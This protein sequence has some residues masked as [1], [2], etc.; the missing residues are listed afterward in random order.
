MK[1]F[2]IFTTA[3]GLGSL[4][5][6]GV[7]TLFSA[8]PSLPPA[9]NVGIE[10]GKRIGLAAAEKRY[11][12]YENNHQ[13]LQVHVNLAQE[14]AR[15]SES[16]LADTRSKYRVA[17]RKLEKGSQE[18][19]AAQES[20]LQ[21]QAELQSDL[22]SAWRSLDEVADGADA[23]VQEKIRRAEATAKLAAQGIYDNLKTQLSI[24]DQGDR[25]LEGSAFF[26]EKS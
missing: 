9:V 5:T 26:G 4:L 8:V 18:A 6:W 11:A 16:V 23:E 25:F 15:A 24:K 7:L 17:V 10:L 21:E 1:P 19:V 2:I 20:A 14:Q 13:E 22:D 12:E 3:F